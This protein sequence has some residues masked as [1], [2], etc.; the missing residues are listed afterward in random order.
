MN[1]SNCIWFSLILRL[2]PPGGAEGQESRSP[3]PTNLELYGQNVDAIGD[4]LISTM[5]RN[6]DRT[7]VVK[8]RGG[9]DSWIVENGLMGSLRRRGFTVRASSDEAVNSILLDL[10]VVEQKVTYRELEDDAS[11]GKQNIERSVSTILAAK[12]FQRSTGE[13]YFGGTIGKSSKDRV[14]RD[15]IPGAENDQI[16]ATQ[17]TLP[18]DGFMKKILEPAV[19]I[20]ATAIAIY[21]LFSVRS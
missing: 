13:V 16:K 1:S 14:A 15:D 18:S 2:F 17:G 12:M 9:G 20:S 8:V 3:I 6:G 21:L 5:P 7:I 4:S 10:N 11:D 19:I